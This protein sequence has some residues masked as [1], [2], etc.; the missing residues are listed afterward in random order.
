MKYGSAQFTLYLVDGN[1]LLPSKVQTFTERRTAILERVDGL[2]DSKEAMGP[3]GLAALTITQTGA[4]FDDRVAGMHETFKTDGRSR[5]LMYSFTGGKTVTSIAGVYRQS[6]DVIAQQGRLTRANVTYQVNGL[7]DDGMLVQSLLAQ[8]GPWTSATVDGLV[9]SANGGVINAQVN[10]LTGFTGV[11]VTVASSADGSTGWTTLATLPVFTTAP[12]TN[13]TV[14]A[15]T[16]H[17]YLR[18]TGATTGTGSVTLA[19]GLTRNP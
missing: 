5:T 16:I 9:E 3:T 17:R 4:F 11:T 15:G 1:D 18:V 2:G 14:V 7:L 10:A 6:Y 13:R 12:V 19:V 8:T